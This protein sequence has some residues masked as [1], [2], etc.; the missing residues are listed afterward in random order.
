MGVKG[1][2]SHDPARGKAFEA[3]NDAVALLGDLDARPQR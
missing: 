1:H 2:V 3:R